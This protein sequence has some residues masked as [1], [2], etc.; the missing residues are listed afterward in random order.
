MMLPLWSS[1]IFSKA[2][3]TAL[4]CTFF[5]QFISCSKL[6]NFILFNN[7]SSSFIHWYYLIVPNWNSKAFFLSKICLLLL[8]TIDMIHKNYKYKSLCEKME[9]NDCIYIYIASICNHKVVNPILIILVI[10]VLV[11]INF[12]ITIITIVVII[13]LIIIIV[14]IIFL[15]ITNLVV[16]IIIIIVIIIL[17]IINIFLFTLIHSFLII[18][19]IL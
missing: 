17:I 6:F 1:C 12:V 5:L 19:L 2:S 16:T 14:V 4:V 7:S 11:I 18:F 9:Y 3:H 10:I 13:F 8:S 15:I